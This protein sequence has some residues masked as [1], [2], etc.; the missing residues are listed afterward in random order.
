MVALR[1]PPTAPQALGVDAM[2]ISLHISMDVSQFALYNLSAN[3]PPKGRNWPNWKNPEFDALIDR[4][5]KSTD[6]Q[7]ILASI[8]KAH[9]IFVDDPPWLFIVHDRNARAMT[10]K[11]KGFVSAQS[12]FQDFTT[13]DMQ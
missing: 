9:E 10:K 13:V 12:W 1:N 4:I 2:N 8:Q 6:S 11:V 5:E 7:E 3:V